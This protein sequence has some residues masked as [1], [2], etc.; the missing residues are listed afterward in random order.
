MDAIKIKKEIKNSSLINEKDRTMRESL[1]F[2]MEE[3]K[4]ALPGGPNKDTIHHWACIYST[5]FR[6]RNREI[7]RIV[8]EELRESSLP[9]AE[10]SDDIMSD[11]YQF[12]H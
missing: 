2:V 11:S 4:R 7:A 10:D 1:A 3:L 9:Q 12:G 8:D 5:A 6:Q